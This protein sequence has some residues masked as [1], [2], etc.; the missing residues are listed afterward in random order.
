[1]KAVNF[2]RVP[3]A[4]GDGVCLV[5]FEGKDARE[6]N[7]YVSFKVFKKKRLF[8]LKQAGKKGDIL[9][10]GDVTEKE[11]YLTGAPVY[12]SSREEVIGKKLKRDMPAS[13]VITPPILEDQLFVERERS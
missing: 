13:T 2:S 3:D 4:Q 5:E 12:P 1:V 11:T 7:A 9:G 10:A 6:R 8:V